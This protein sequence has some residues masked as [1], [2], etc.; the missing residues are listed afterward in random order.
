M[1]YENA[2]L[3]SNAPHVC[4]E[5]KKNYCEKYT[6]NMEMKTASSSV[7]SSQA[8][9]G[10]HE[11]QRGSVS[12]G[13]GGIVVCWEN[14]VAAVGLLVDGDVVGQASQE[15]QFALDPAENLLGGHKDL[16]VSEAD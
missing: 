1:V 3:L 13:A 2:M 9:G 15:V 4:R 10:S 16:E 5:I 12:V 6:L 11:A 7:S 14:S 8:L